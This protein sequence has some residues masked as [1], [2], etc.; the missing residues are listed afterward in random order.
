MNTKRLCSLGILDININ[1]FLYE[2]QMM[3]MNINLDSYN[4]IDDLSGLFQILNSNLFS[5]TNVNNNVKEEEKS[6]NFINYE[7]IISLD[8]DNCLINT[9]LYINKAYKNKTFIEF[10]IPDKIEF[11]EKNQYIKN[12][13]DEILTKNYLFIV[14]SD[15]RNKQFSKINFIIK[16]IDDIYENIKLTKKIE[17]ICNNHNSLNKNDYDSDEN[18]DFEKS[19][20]KQLNY[21]FNKIDFFIVDLKQIRKILMKPKYIYNFLLKIIKEYPK[22]KTIL[23]ID[24]NII[25]EGCEKEDIISINKYIKL[26]DILFSFKNNMN[27]FLKFYYSSTKREITD[28]NPSKIYFLLKNKNN[29]INTFDLITKD[30]F[31]LRKTIPRISIIFDEFN[32]VHI[33]EQDMKNKILSYNKIFQLFLTQEELTEE[34]NI[35]MIS[36]SLKLYHLFIS[37]FLSRLIYNKP[38]DICFEAGNLLMKK[39]L[40]ILSRTDINIKNDIYKIHVKSKG[41]KIL[42]KLKNDIDKENH[43]VLDCINMEKSK[44][45][46][47]NI[48]TDSNCLGYLTKKYFFKNY[49]QPT[50]ID[51]VTKLLKERKNKTTINSPKKE[52]KE[53][54]CYSIKKEKTDL[55]N[56]NIKRLLPFIIN[57]DISNYKKARKNLNSYDELNLK[58]NSYFSHSRYKNLN[59]IRK[60]QH[61]KNIIK[62]CLSNINKAENYNKY[63]FKMY[64]PDKKF[65]DYIKENNL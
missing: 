12:F 40:N 48:L 34:K 31:K 18:N 64:I 63:I 52:I 23:I 45:K 61:T 54:N 57:N 50:L 62:N 13:I 24:E 35:Q 9:L 2:S 26:F 16:I 20:L 47:Y 65:R 33:Y 27:N 59:I 6:I 44:Q 32:S 15:K 41:Y 14:E 49:K 29:I 51:K 4:N 1:L 30:Y 28:K 5:K 36:N 60:T 53:I 10:I 21:N 17:I 19:F 25:N 8:S 56:K 38:F 11:S 22:L 42:Q 37:G 46:E 43:F 7:N 58:T 55:K 39:S 3:D